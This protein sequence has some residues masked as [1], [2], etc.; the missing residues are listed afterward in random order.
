MPH[1]AAGFTNVQ[2]KW[3]KATLGDWARNSV[4]K[5]AGQ[6]CKAQ[7]L[8]GM[9]GY[10]IWVLTKLGKLEPWSVEKVQVFLARVK[11]EMETPGVHAYLFKRRAWGQKPCDK[12]QKAEDES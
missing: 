11:R 10:V 6:F 7:M 4:L 9:E 12:N 1:I 8:E 2:E 3:Y 5:E